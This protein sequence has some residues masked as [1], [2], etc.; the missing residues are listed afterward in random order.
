MKASQTA[1]ALVALVV[2]GA[3]YVLVPRSDERVAM[4]VRDGQIEAA[5]AELE[6]FVAQGDRRPRVLAALA[7][8]QLRAGQP[9]VAARTMEDYVKALPA[10]GPALKLLAEMY[11]EAGDIDET[12]G[13]LERLARVDPKPKTL[14]YM[15]ALSRMHGRYDRERRILGELEARRALEIDDRLRLAELR[16][17]DTDYVGATEVLFRLEPELPEGEESHRYMLFELLA[18]QHRWDDA[19]RFGKH[20][21]AASRKPWIALALFKRLAPDAPEAAL[22]GLAV[23]AAEVF[24]EQRF[25]FASSLAGLGRSDGARVLCQA[26]MREVTE[27]SDAEINDFMSVVARLHEPRLALEALARL[28]GRPT[29]LDAQAA[30]AESVA[31]IFGDTALSSLRSRLGY[32]VLARRP[33]FASRLALREGNSVLAARIL[34]GVDPGKMPAPE[35]RQWVA[36]LATALPEE[37]ALL[38]LTRLMLADKLPQDLLPAYL[39][40]ARRTGRTAEY[41]IAIARTARLATAGATGAATPAGLRNR[42]E[43]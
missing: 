10:D 3:G 8:L 34:L 24:P 35:R 15:L 19:T 14:A 40:L 31:L 5:T 16:A 4:L 13:A 7:R 18:R 26:W 25:T 28:A 27:P 21:L 11:G 38:R 6:K 2:A 39:E 12:L 37:A 22:A 1:V 32:D 17:A 23:S 30:L 43:D 29:A 36:L 33:L 20:W 41:G 42:M 9:A